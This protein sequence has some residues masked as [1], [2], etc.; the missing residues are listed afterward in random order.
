MRLKRFTFMISLLGICLPGY[1]AEK[2]VYGLAEHVYIPE[3]K[4]QLPAKI[5]TGAQTSSLSAR[6]IQT[7]RRDGEPWV[8]FELGS[9]SEK[10]GII[11]KPVL[12]KSRIKRRASDYDPNEEKTYSKR[13]VIEMEI[14]LGRQRETI[15]VNLTDRSAFKYPMLI[16][17]DTLKQLDVLIDPNLKYAVGRPVCL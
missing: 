9:D 1:A 10:Q 17:S 13:P 3:L 12:R 2:L 11:E 16:G 7:F 4:V 8:R 14:C 6:N 15:E 5:D